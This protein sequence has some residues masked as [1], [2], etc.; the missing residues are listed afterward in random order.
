V[1]AP[2]N[3]AI[4]PSL[5]VA[6]RMPVTQSTLERLRITDLGVTLC[7]KPDIRVIASLAN[8]KRLQKFCEEHYQTRPTYN[9]VFSHPITE[10]YVSGTPE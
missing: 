5:G 10:I 4:I 8:I 1:Y 2:V 6:T 9:L 3:G 7:T